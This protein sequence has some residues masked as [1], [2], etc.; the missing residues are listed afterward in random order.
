MYVVIF[1]Q[2]ARDKEEAEEEARRQAEEEARRQAEEEAQRQ[3]EEEAWREEEAARQQQ[4]AEAQQEYEETEAEATYEET[5][6]ARYESEP[7]DFY[8]EVTQEQ[9]TTQEE[10]QGNIDTTAKSIVYPY[11]L[12]CSAK[13]GS[14]EEELITQLVQISEKRKVT[15]TCSLIIPE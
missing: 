14:M 11:S 4:E 6:E 12:H 10:V 7:T 5:G 3:A 15:R 1:Q 9:Q 13:C 8:E 2:E